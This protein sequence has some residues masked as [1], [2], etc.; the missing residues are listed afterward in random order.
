LGLALKHLELVVVE[1]ELGQKVLMEVVFE[2]EV[3]LEVQGKHIPYNHV[4]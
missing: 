2:G 4:Y 1:Q 3:D